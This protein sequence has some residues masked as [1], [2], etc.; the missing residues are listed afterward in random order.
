MAYLAKV[1]GTYR[2]RVYINLILFKIVRGWRTDR[3]S[4][5]QNVS[6]ADAH[7]A[8]APVKGVPVAVALDVT[9]TGVEFGL[10]VLTE[11]F[12]ISRVNFSSGS[13][14]FHWEPI[15]GVI[16]DGVASFTAV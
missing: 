9:P 13:K 6:A 7:F 14:S 5:S 12:P 1:E 15:K 11:D 2:T 3:F 16:L 10:Q 4:W 8:W